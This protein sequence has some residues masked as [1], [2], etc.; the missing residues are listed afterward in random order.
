MCRLTIVVDFLTVVHNSFCRLPNL[1]T[2]RCIECLY[3][4]DFRCCDGHAKTKVDCVDME[5]GKY[6]QTLLRMQFWDN[7]LV[8]IRMN[9]YI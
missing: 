3:A 1:Y 7:S 5:R 9:L 8:L 2:N 4:Y 6:I